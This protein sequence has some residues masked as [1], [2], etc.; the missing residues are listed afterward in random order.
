MTLEGNGGRLGY[1]N[2][3]V[4]TPAA[5]LPASVAG[6]AHE[7]AI[8]LAALIYGKYISHVS[9][10]SDSP[11]GVAPTPGTRPAPG[12]GNSQTDDTDNESSDPDRM[13][14]ETFFTYPGHDSCR[15]GPHVRGLTQTSTRMERQR[16]SKSAETFRLAVG[17]ESRATEASPKS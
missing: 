9:A 10:G 7:F 5:P 16:S 11:N 8:R 1:W 3:S 14:D 17:L 2:G 13:D 4:P 12:E 15:H 6:Q